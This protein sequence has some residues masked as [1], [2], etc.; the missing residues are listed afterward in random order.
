MRSWSP[1]SGD[2]HRIN[3][4]VVPQ[5]YRL[6]ILSLAHDANLAGHCGVKKTYHRVLRNFFWPGLKS[7]VVNYCRS[8]HTCQLVGKPNKPIS[9]APLHPIPVLGEPFERVL[10]DCVGPLPKTKSGYQYI[11][12]IMCAATRFLEAIPLRTLKTKNIVK[13][14]TKF[15][16]TFGLP[17][18]FQTDQGTNFMSKVFAQVMNELKMKHQTSTPY[19]P[20]SQ[21]ALERFHQTLKTMLRKYCLESGKS[22]DEGLPLLLFAVR[23]TIQE[24]LG[25]SP[26][27]LVFGHTVRDPLKLV[28]EKWLSKS[29]QTEHNVLD[30]VS[31]FRERLF[32]ACQLAQE[33]LAK[34]QS[35]MKARYDKKSVSRNFIPGQK[36]LVLLPIGGSSLHAQFSGPY[37]VDRKINE[38]NYVIK[39]PD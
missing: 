18:V 19:H 16:S 13:A 24:S 20:E 26:A 38:T 2:L 39:T 4:V 7:D 31:S 36:V 25:F 32:H 34:A 30:Y 22:W 23:E 9:P 12:T 35:K 10:L 21:G 33:N 37:E 14:L 11:L 8:C 29:H 3:Q 28:K 6:Q 1:D 27:A 15:F 17:K 5:D